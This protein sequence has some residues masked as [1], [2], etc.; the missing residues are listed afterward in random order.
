MALRRALSTCRSARFR[1]DGPRE[2][3]RDGGV[4]R[5]RFALAALGCGAEEHPNDPRPVAADP[6]QRRDQP[7]LGHGAAARIGVGPEPDAA[8]P[9]EPQQAQPPIHTDAPLERRLRRRQPHPTDSKLVIRGPKDATSACWSPTATAPT[10]PRCRPAP[11]RSAPPTS[12]APSRPGS[13]S[14][15]TAPPRRT[16]SCCP[17]RWPSV[18][19]RP[20][21]TRLHFSDVSARERRI[22]RATSDLRFSRRLGAHQSP[23]VEA[24]CVDRVLAGAGPQTS[25]VRAEAARGARR[26]RQR[27]WRVRDRSVLASAGF[28][29][30]RSS[31][32]HAWRAKSPISR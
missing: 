2:R 32:T 21:A 18:S 20:R 10:R 30:G 17:S 11:T 9:A 1:R 25:V 4:R 24:C 22:V 5:S 16:T 31:R 26:C 8:D 13:S 29:C 12:P 7:R 19:R 6:G 28:V 14:A 23:A 3:Q 15:P 27:C